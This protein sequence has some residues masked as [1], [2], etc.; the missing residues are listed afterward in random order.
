M[1]TLFLVFSRS[2]RVLVGL[3]WWLRQYRICLQCRSPGFDPWVRNIPWRRKWQPTP[4]FLPGGFHG[5]GNLAGCSPWGC[6][7]SDTTER[8]NTTT[9]TSRCQLSCSI[10]QEQSSEMKDKGT[11]CFKR[12]YHSLFKIQNLFQHFQLEMPKSLKPLT[13]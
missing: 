2:I 9:A 6:K 13:G 7:E 12:T 8:L 3:P 1:C 11:T 4:V 5:Q 10:A